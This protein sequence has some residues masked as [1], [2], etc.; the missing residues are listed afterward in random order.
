[1]KGR[2][3]VL[4][5]VREKRS[6]EEGGSRLERMR[7]T[8]WVCVLGGVCDIISIKSCICK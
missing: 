6:E 5:K 8:E 2:K 1:M 7:D 3:S 4:H